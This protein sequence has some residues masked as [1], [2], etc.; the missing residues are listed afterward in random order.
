MAKYLKLSLITHDYDDKAFLKN[1]LSFNERP[2][3]HEW[4][5]YRRLKETAKFA[6]N[7]QF[8]FYTT[9]LLVSPYQDTDKIIKLGERAGKEEGVD[10]LGIDFREGFSYAHKISR[11]LKVYHQNYCGCL[12]SEKEAIEQRKNKKRK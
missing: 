8:K 3:M 4:C 11:E 6:R 10:F 12:F 7:H 2:Q 9:T 5:W 1:L